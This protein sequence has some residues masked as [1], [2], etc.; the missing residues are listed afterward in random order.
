MDKGNHNEEALKYLKTKQLGLVTA[1][2]KSSHKEKLQLPIRELEVLSLANGKTVAFKDYSLNFHSIDGRLLLVYDRASKKRSLQIFARD[3]KEK[4][5]EL[6]EFLAEKLNVKKW[7]D[8]DAV[9]K[10][11]ENLCQNS[12]FQ[13]IFQFKIEGDYAQLQVSIK[14]K[15]AAKAEYCRTLG[16]S[17][18]FSNRSSWTPKEI[19]Q[20]YRDKYVIEDSMKQLKNPKSIAL[21]PMYHYTNLSIHL[22]VFICV[23]AY[24]FQSLTRA[25][26]KQQNIK[27]SHHELTESL[28]S[29]QLTEVGKG[30]IPVALRQT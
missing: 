11:L 23:M 12:L 29:M 16:K 30:Q 9:T 25:L 26:L 24:L 21:R 2:R 17:F 6:H 18:L 27:V 10:K 28:L 8:K 15:S 5:I 22:H 3:L 14:E 1:V 4:R 7:R 13:S 19:I 20:I